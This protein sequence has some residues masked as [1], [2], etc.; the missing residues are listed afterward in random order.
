M[1]SCFDPYDIEFVKKQDI[2]EEVPDGHSGAL[3][4]KITRNKDKFFLK[5]FN[6]K[7]DEQNIIKIKQYLEIYKKLNINSLDIIDYGAI[8]ELNKY[9]IVYNFIEGINLKVY[10]QGDK[11]TQQEVI[12]LGKHIGRELLKLKNHKDYNQ[13]LFEYEDIQILVNSVTNNFD[14]ILEDD[15]GKSIIN[16]YFK[17]EEINQFKKKIK[18]YCPSVNDDKV[19]LIHGDIKMSNFII[20]KNKKIYIIDI[21]SMQINYHI[22]NFK[23]QMTWALFEGNEKATQFAKGYFDGI[24]N[25]TRP[26]N[27]NNRVIFITILNFFNASY[28]IFQKLQYYKLD[29]YLEKC[30]HLFDKINKMNLNKEF[31]L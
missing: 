16:R 28:D 12:E 20:D 15:I 19:E 6:E 13:K 9:Y 23:H 24:Y 29:M 2:I 22:M 27:F 14:L 5:I 11:C 25:N 4:Y 31:I 21:E 1:D 18:E 17:I 8:R 3:L 30:R 7:F 26:S 10:T